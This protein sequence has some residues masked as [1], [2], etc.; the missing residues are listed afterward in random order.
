MGIRSVFLTAILGVAL[1]AGGHASAND[2]HGVLQV[3]KGDVQIKSVKDGKTSKAKVGG[4][5]F[6]KDTI[7]T[8]KDSRAKIVMVDKNVINVSPDS[9]LEIQNYEYAPE[10]GKKDVLLNV[11]YGKV[12]SKVEQKYDGKGAKFQVKTPT[13]VAGVRGTDFMASFNQSNRASSV[14]TFEG[15][16]EFG[17]PGP[18]GSI[19]NPVFVNPGQMSEA[20]GGSAPPPPQPVPP[21]QLARMDR[22]SNAEAGGSSSDSRTPADDSKRNEG[23]KDDAK[24]KQDGADKD[25]GAGND[26]EKSAA[27]EDGADK[28]KGAGN[29]KDKQ[30]GPGRDQAKD[31]QGDGRGGNAGNSNAPAPRPGGVPAPTASSSDPRAPASAPVGAP[32]PPPSGDTSV[33]TGPTAPPPLPPPPPP[34]SLI[35]EPVACADC[36]TMV[37]PPEPPPPPPPIFEPAPVVVVPDCGTTCQEIIQGKSSLTVNVSQ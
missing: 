20:V 9:S 35:T 16:V 37:K 5:I 29:D 33:V 19:Q 4:K 1:M 28:N 32:P 22:E 15:R 3:V 36:S 17:Q 27:K 31:R 23:K 26:K 18:G 13:A 25:R 24:D 21:Q 34:D 6:P 12:R 30:N 14:V 10:Q 11:I 7:I 2:V 8:G